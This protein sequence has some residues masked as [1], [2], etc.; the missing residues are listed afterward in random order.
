LT[1]RSR[2]TAKSAK[3]SGEAFHAC[4]QTGVQSRRV[5]IHYG[6]AARELIIDEDGAVTRRAARS[7]ARSG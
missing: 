6:V 5:P 2:D 3:Q 4:M 1:G 7:A